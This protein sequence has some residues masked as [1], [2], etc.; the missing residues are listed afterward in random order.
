M[1]HNFAVK[2]LWNVQHTAC[3]LYLLPSD[4][5]LLPALQLNLDGY[6]F[7]DDREVETAVTRWLITPATDCYQQGIVKFNA[8]HD[9]CISCC[10]NFVEK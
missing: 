7:E 8:R 5:H 10:R 4:Y 2:E 3:S 1:L 9:R 6:T